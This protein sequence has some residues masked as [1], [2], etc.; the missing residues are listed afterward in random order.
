MW[1]YPFHWC[2]SHRSIFISVWIILTRSRGMWGLGG[3]GG[4][5]A[6]WLS[7]GIAGVRR[8]G[9]LGCRR[10]WRRICPTLLR[11]VCRH[12]LRG[13][14]LWLR[15]RRISRGGCCLLLGQTA[16]SIKFQQLRW[17]SLLVRGWS[18]RRRIRHRVLSH[19]YSSWWLLRWHV[20]HRRLESFWLRS[21]Q[22]YQNGNRGIV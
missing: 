16:S 2:F 22:C 6:W 11:P 9:R 1:R 17:N 10:R 3:N 13:I 18:G 19:W 14:L 8:D 12:R 21:T 4:S 15:G 5:L 20:V 7:G